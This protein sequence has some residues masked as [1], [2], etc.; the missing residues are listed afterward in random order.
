MGQIAAAILLIDN[1]K[2]GELT[3]ASVSVKSNGQLITTA[4]EVMKTIGKA[5]AEISYTVAMPIGGLP[6]NPAQLAI[7]QQWCVVQ[8]VYAGLNLI[9]QGTFDQTDLS[10][11][12]GSGMTDQK[13]RFSG[14]IELA[15]EA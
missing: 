5:T 11:N 4:D 14:S 2:V 3:E 6:I 8:F 13:P 12:I 1:K 10:T 15:P 9:S 7:S